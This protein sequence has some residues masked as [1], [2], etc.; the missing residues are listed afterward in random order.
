MLNYSSNHR[1]HATFPSNYNICKYKYPSPVKH[2]PISNTTHTTESIPPEN[3]TNRLLLTDTSQ[4]RTC[5]NSHFATMCD[6][7]ASGMTR[8]NH[9][10]LPIVPIND[11]S[12]PTHN[13]TKT[14]NSIQEST[15]GAA[16]HQSQPTPNTHTHHNIM[17][18]ILAPF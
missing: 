10:P 8:P 5:N 2:T 13:N 17:T 4:D 9:P 16:V 18:K 7:L 3:T 11:H 14:P 6:L 1:D 12:I 15:K